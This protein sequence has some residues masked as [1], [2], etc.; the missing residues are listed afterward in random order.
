MKKFF[1]LLLFS[2]FLVCNGCGIVGYEGKEKAT[3]LGERIKVTVETYGSAV[4]KDINDLAIIVFED[5]NGLNELNYSATGRVLGVTSHEPEKLAEQAVEAIKALP[6]DFW[7]RL[8]E[9]IAEKYEPA[10]A[11]DSS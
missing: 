10:D 4:N 5:P 8:A 11:N 2:L 3:F 1:L 9:I 6:H 7:L